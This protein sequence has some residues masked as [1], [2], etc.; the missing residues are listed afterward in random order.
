MIHKAKQKQEA[1]RKKLAATK[2]AKQKAAAK[3]VDK[4]HS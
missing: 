2:H 3:K 1:D 4:K